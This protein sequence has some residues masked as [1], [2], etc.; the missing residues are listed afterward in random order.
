MHHVASTLPA[1]SAS[2]APAAP[3]ACP[4]LAYSAVLLGGLPAPAV[5]SDMAVLDSTDPMACSLAA[6]YGERVT[7]FRATALALI[8]EALLEDAQ[9]RLG[10]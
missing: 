6:A 3:P 1:P 8:H 7:G 10:L 2:L 5:P 9:R 4:A